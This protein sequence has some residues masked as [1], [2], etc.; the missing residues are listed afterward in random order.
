MD[1]NNASATTVDRETLVRVATDAIHLM[2]DASES[3]HEPFQHL[4]HPDATN[5]ESVTEPPAARGTGPQAFHAT[6]RW[7]Q[8]AFSDLRFTVR[9]AAVDADVVVLRVS[10]AGRH[11]GDF[12]VYA[13]DATIERVFVPTGKTFDVTQTHWHRIRDGKVVEHW[14]NRD[15]Q[16]MATQAGWVPPSPLY[17]LRCG[18]ATA[19]ARRRT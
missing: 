10:M 9:N 15:D 7:L 8:A 19:R 14:A 4:I 17:L 12:V 2:A 13:P 16:G 6:A 11:S 18:R 1:N 3:G 5:H